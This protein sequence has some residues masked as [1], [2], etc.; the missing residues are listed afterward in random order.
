[1]IAKHFI[2]K[3]TKLLPSHEMK[4]GGKK[5]SIESQEQMEAQHAPPF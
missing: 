3:K 1:M 2:M 5:F 4:E